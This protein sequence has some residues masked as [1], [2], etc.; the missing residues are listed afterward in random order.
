MALKP[1]SGTRFIKMKFNCPLFSK[2]ELASMHKNAAKALA[3][4][5]GLEKFSNKRKYWVHDPTRNDLGCE[6]LNEIA[7]GF[8]DWIGD[9][10]S[11]KMSTM[12][13]KQFCCFTVRR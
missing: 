12:T 6:K 9:R 11:H 4:K 8:Y 13:G 7:T 1:D 5:Q 3:I 10:G 2:E